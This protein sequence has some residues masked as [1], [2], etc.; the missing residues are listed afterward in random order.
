MS[1]NFDPTQGQRLDSWKEIAAFLGRGERTVKRWE[2]ERGLPVRRVPGGG[3]SA[4]FAYTKELSE[5]L[6]GKTD[7]LEDGDTASVNSAQPEAGPPSSDTAV[8]PQ[9]VG[10]RFSPGRVVFWLILLALAGVMVVYYAASR[11]GLPAKALAA[12]QPGEPIDSSLGPD[13]VAVLPFTNIRGDAGT[14]YLIDG[15]TESL[16]G[17]LAHLPQLKVRSRDS[18]FHYKAKNADLRAAGSELGVSVL[19]SGRVLVQGD[20]IDV[21][22]ELT[23]VRENTEIWG[24]RYTGKTANLIS[25]QQRMAGDIA[26]ELRSSLSSAS[27]QRAMQQG[28]MDPDAYALYLKGRYEW[29]KRTL[30]DLQ[31]AISYFNEAIG[32]DSAYA[33]AYAGVA[34]AYSVMPNFGGNP[35]EDFPKSNVAARKALEL[36]PSLARPHAVLGINETEYDWDFVSGE[37]EFKKAIEL[38]PNDATAHQWYAEKLSQQ[39]RHAEALAEIRRAQELDPS[40]LVIRRVLAGTLLDAGKADEA[41]A[42]CKQLAQ[43]HPTFAMAHNCLAFAYWDKGMYAQMVE[44]CQTYGQMTG[45]PEDV[46][47]AD[48]LEQ[49]FRSAGWKGAMRQAAARFEDLRKNGYAS[50]FKIAQ[51]YASIGDDAQAFHWLDIADR[52][53]D[54]LLLAMGAPQFDGMRADPRFAQLA[55]KVGLPA[56]GTSHSAS[57]QR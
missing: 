12:R 34:D 16:I 44:E 10:R 46:V 26:K 41:I 53:H 39:D 38:D 56:P 28:T 9:P 29:N 18:V 13:S 14:D 48:A 25:I 52:E 11:S 15:I 51:F 2:T 20:S 35:A 47:L 37:A 45:N 57:A 50:P 7:E 55:H 6:K 40:S 42:T 43:E 32:K 5:W 27:R 30:G 4:V 31:N 1:A 23:R 36:D 49:G 54:R 17:N 21:S 8:V 22:V 24:H 19:V 33:L 3:R